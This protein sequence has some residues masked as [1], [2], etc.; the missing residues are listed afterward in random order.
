[1][2]QP[3]ETIRGCHTNIKKLYNLLDRMNKT[4]SAQKMATKLTEELT[5]K[6]LKVDYMDPTTPIKFLVKASKAQ[7]LDRLVKINEFDP[8]GK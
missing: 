8:T 6:M 4:Y 5:S 3:D 1:M 2:S 7:K